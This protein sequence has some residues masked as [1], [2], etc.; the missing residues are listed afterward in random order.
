MQTNGSRPFK[1]FVAHLFPRRVRSED[2]RLSYT[3]CLGGL[4]LTA[5]IILLLSGLLL[6][7][8]YQ[9]TPE[10]AFSS[11]LYLESHVFGGRYIRSLHRLSSHAFLVLVVLHTLRVLLT[12]AYRKPR[13]LNWLIGFGLLCLS[14]FEAY[15][16]YLLPRDQ[17][18]FWAART[19]L[20]LLKSVPF[21]GFLHE[22]L[23]PDGIR[24]GLTLLRFYVIHIVLVPLC[25]LALTSLHFYRIRK[26]RGLLPYL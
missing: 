9:P 17:L 23:A 6:L 26:N 18:G 25:I 15:T 19:G 4:S 10:R 13:E 20:S 21:G 14:L 16:G 2:L 12:G 7:V 22:L 1:E 8:Y 11:I 3:F 5:F 24:G